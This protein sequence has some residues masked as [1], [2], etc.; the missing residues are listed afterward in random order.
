[1]LAVVAAIVAVPACKSETSREAEKA[2]ENVREQAED[3]R[4]EKRELDE[5]RRDI[6]ENIAEESK[7]VVEQSKDVSKEAEELAGAQ[8]DFNRRKAI[9]VD[10]LRMLHSV[11]ATQPMLINVFASVEPFTERAR[12][13]ANEKLT[14]FQMRLDEAANAIEA[15]QSAGSAS[16]EARDDE[17]DEAMNRLEEAREDAWEALH[18]GDR[19]GTS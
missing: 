13:S 15:L 9:R 8:D 1:M 19:I 6:S 14:L 10:E 2:A 16:F 11:I 4:E 17:A 18:D 12:A 7:D 3:L 5:E